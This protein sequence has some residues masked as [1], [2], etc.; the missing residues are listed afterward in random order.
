MNNVTFEIETQ[1]DQTSFL[2]GQTLSGTVRWMCS[3]LPDDASLHLIWYTEGRGDEDVGLAEKCEFENPQIS[4][5]HP[6]RFQLPAG[7]YSF[8]G[9]LISLI[10]ALE[11]KVDKEVVRKEIVL[12]PGEKEITLR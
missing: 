3:E 2:P 4:D 12:S 9:S 6:F 1:N 11:L 8:S 10:W 7:P 5:E